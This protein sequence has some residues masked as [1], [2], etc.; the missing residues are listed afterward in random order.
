MPVPWW[1]LG[2]PEGQNTSACSWD[3]AQPCAC[4]GWHGHQDY[5]EE[6]AWRLWQCVHGLM[7]LA[8]GP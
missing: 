8:A 3:D 5:V 1:V 4:L 2:S 7:W 6:L